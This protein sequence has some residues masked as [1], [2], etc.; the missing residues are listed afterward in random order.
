MAQN[1]MCVKCGFKFKEP[2]I[3]GRSKPLALC[4]KCHDRLIRKLAARNWS[5]RQGCCGGRSITVRQ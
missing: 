3:M 2:L 4:P 5:E 1:W